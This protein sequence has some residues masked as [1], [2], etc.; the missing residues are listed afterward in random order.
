MLPT[1]AV[2]LPESQ[3]VVGAIKSRPPVYAPGCVIWQGIRARHIGC[4]VAW[5]RIVQKI[6]QFRLSPFFRNVGHEASQMIFRK[7]ILQRRSKQEGLIKIT[8]AK[9]LVHIAILRVLLVL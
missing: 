4:A 3:V 9:A 6:A 7:P 5:A 2:T 1:V 8:D